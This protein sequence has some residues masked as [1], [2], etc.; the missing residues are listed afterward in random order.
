MNPV[1]KYRNT[2]FRSPK[3]FGAALVVLMVL[4]LFPVSHGYAATEDFPEDVVRIEPGHFSCSYRGVAHDYILDLPEV[5]EGSPLILILPGYGSTAK[6]F[7]Q[8]TGFEKDANPLGYTVVYV[9]GAPAQEDGTSSV[10]WNYGQWETGNDDLGFLT[11]LARF[12]RQEYHADGQRIFAVG[13]SNGAFMVHRL[14]IEAS[15]TFSAVVS[16]AGAM[17]ESV[18]EKRPDL[19]SVGVFQISGEKDDVIPKHC[20]G[21]AEYSPSPAIEDV[22][23]YYA[24]ANG[25]EKAETETAGKASLL[26]KYKGSSSGRQ[27][28][29]LL[30]REG[31]HSWSGESVTGICTNRLIL[32]YLST[33]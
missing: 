22:M 25:L 14:A 29:H 15:D 7:R 27:V 8:N 24:E 20:D 3:H 6:S 4:L 17:S 21:S 33:Q 19:L 16:V 31:R 9:T 10:G 32:D 30:V 12:L 13:F 2:T 1:E 26:T 28:W 11:A 18:W 5:P 23:D